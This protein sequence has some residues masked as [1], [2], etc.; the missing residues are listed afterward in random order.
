[1]TMEKF[2]VAVVGYGPVGMAA[3]AL[4]GQAGHKVVVLERYA[5]LYNLPRAAIFDDET[6][7]TFARLGIAEALLPKVNAQRNYE[8]RNADGELLIEHEFALK[9]ASGWSEWYMMYQPDL[10]DALDRLCR[11]MPNVTVRFSS[12]VEGYLESADGVDITVP[13]GTV[14]ASYVVACDG[15]NG[16]TRGWMGAELED[17]GFSEPWLVCDFRLT[18]RVDVPLARQVCDPRQPQSIISLG[19]DHHRFS[20]MLDSEEAFLTERDPERVWARVKDYLGPDQAEL[21]RVATYTFRSLIASPWR[22]GR[23]VLAGDAAHQMPPFLG[24]GMCSGVRDAQN[25]AFKLDLLLAGKADEGIL[26][27]YQSEREPHVAA[28]V[29][30]GIELGK[31]QTMRDPEKARQR[32]EQFIANRRNNL[33]PEKLKFPGLGPGFI[34]PTSHPANGQLFI[35]DEVRDGTVSGRFDEVFGY[36]FRLLCSGE[37]YRETTSTDADIPGDVVVIDPETGRVSGSFTDVNGSYVKWFATN[38]C[39]AVLI[40]PDFYVYGA[41]RTNAEFAALLHEY[42]SACST[43]S[44]ITASVGV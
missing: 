42:H 30:K 11:S 16:F 5:G 28:V 23:I 31:V 4:L 20:F 33:K 41:A 26:D 32:D 40:R 7:R 29:H 3:A 21:I 6:M 34:A 9:G 36:G 10:E 14:T 25:L 24:Q 22:Q 15:G 8:W 37:W 43:P 35:Q 44:S 19:P 18:G 1:M 2:D 12:P 38:D 27:T 13:G 17:F 39:S